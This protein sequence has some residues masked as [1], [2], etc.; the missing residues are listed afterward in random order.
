[1]REREYNAAVEAAFESAREAR[2]GM[3]L[4][5]AVVGTVAGVVLVV[6]ALVAWQS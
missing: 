3:L 5:A 4:V 1:M 2:A 6:T